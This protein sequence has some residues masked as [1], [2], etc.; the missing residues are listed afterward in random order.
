M[1]ALRS[2][3]PSSLQP[4][5]LALFGARVRNRRSHR[6]DSSSLFEGSES[7]DRYRRPPS[8]HSH[9]HH[10]CRG[11]ICLLH[12]TPSP[13][14]PVLPD[15]SLV[16]TEPTPAAPD[17]IDRPNT[18]IRAGLCRCTAYLPRQLL[19]EHHWSVASTLAELL[20]DTSETVSLYEDRVVQLTTAGAS[21]ETE[22]VRVRQQLLRRC[23]R[24]HCCCWTEI[25]R[26]GRRR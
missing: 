13:L 18:D 19:D 26:V 14:P 25:R 21:Q 2:R 20:D 11:L 9:N 16:P 8:K 17:K 1:A 22:E 10:S 5:F 12:P 15:P 4:E 6:Q 3:D 23:C 7:C 24:C